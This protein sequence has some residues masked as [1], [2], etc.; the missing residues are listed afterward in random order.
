MKRSFALRVLSPEKPL[1]DM[2]VEEIRAPGEA[3]E[4]G[5]FPDHAAMISAL[6]PGVL[7]VWESGGAGP[8]HYY[9]GGGYLQVSENKAVVLVEVIDT[10]GDLD[11]VRADAAEKRA[12]ERLSNGSDAAIDISRA[13]KSLER[14][15]ARKKLISMKNL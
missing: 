3:G 4:M 9:V 13:L 6:R 8:V 2:T 15:K 5:I 11:Q 10:M 12:L 14:A 1:A 7:S